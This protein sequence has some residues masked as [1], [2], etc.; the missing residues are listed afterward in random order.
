MFWLQASSHQDAQ[1]TMDKTGQAVKQG[2][3]DAM[4]T[5]GNMKHKAASTAEQV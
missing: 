4:K 3:D 1:A 5:G 2:A